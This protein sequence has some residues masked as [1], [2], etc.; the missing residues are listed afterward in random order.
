MASQ[1][2]MHAQTD[3]QPRFIMHPKVTSKSLTQISN[4][5]EMDVNNLA[6]TEIPT[7]VQI[8]NASR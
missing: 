1:A 3:G 6:K 5:Q 7:F 4:F 8:P 2:E